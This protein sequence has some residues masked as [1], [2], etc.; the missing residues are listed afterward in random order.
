MALLPSLNSYNIHARITIF[1]VPIFDRASLDEHVALTGT[2]PASWTGRLTTTDYS[3]LCVHC[4]FHCLR[5]ACSS[6][7]GKTDRTFLVTFITNSV[8]P[9]PEGSSPHSQ[10]PANGPYPEPGEFTPHTP[11]PS[12][13]P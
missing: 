9:E 13:S 1:G 5:N 7:P 3:L 8:A 12:Q 4:V 11:P 6:T 2:K 10:Q